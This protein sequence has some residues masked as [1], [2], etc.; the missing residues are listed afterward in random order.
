MLPKLK[1][2]YNGVF[3]LNDRKTA[4]NSCKLPKTILLL[5]SK[6]LDLPW[7]ANQT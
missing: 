6:V 3:Y 2:G 7:R 4:K 1:Y 5:P